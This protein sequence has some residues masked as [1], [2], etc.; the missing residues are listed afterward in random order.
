MK[1]DLSHV[2]RDLYHVERDLYHVK[3]TY[4]MWKET[5]IIWKANIMH[6]SPKTD[7]YHVKRDLFF[8]KWKNDYRADFWESLAILFFPADSLMGQMHLHLITARLL[9][10]QHAGIYIYIYIYN[11][12]LHMNRFTTWAISYGRWA[13]GASKDGGKDSFAKRCVLV[14]LTVFLT[15]NVAFWCS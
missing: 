10:A 3:E 9:A 15:R 5:Y 7:L 1:R 14:F 12:A 8:E 13:S 4:I 11:F 6:E 2:K